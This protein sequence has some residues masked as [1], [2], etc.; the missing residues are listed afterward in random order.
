MSG[1]VGE[2]RSER[3]WLELGCISEIQRKKRFSL[4]FHS[5]LINFSRSKMKIYSHF[6]RLIE[7]L[8]Y[9]CSR[10]IKKVWILQKGF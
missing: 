8:H 2:M 10:L 7:I 5:I 6:V 1:E 3:G 4:V 9:L